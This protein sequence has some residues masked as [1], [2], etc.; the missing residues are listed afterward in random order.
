M[1]HFKLLESRDSFL[2]F[3]GSHSWRMEVPR[4][5]AELELLLL[6]YPTATSMPDLSCICSLHHGLWQCWIL[7]PLSEARDR[8]CFLT[9]TSQVHYHWAA[10]QTLREQGFF[11]HSLGSRSLLMNRI[12]LFFYV[13]SSFSS[14]FSL[15]YSPHLTH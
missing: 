10:V 8:T 13:H 7:N 3:L 1:W 9:D 14:T 15:T 6:A 2:F 11:I 4:L 12:I 5:G